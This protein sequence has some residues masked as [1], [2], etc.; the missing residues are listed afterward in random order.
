M[1]QIRFSAVLA[2]ALVM[3]GPAA[4]QSSCGS[5]DFATPYTQAFIDGVAFEGAARA[6]ETITSIPDGACHQDAVVERL[7][8]SLGP[9]VGYKAAATSAGA[10]RQLGLDG[11]VLG[12]LFED[13]LRPGGATIRVDQGA[14]LIFELDLLARVGD[15]AINEATTREEALEA[16]D[17]FVPFV[18][19]GD[20]MVP[21]GAP[22]TGPLLQAMNAG[23][24]LGVTGEPIPADGLTVDTLAA[25]TGT[26]DEGRRRRRRSA[27][28]CSSG[29]STR[30]RALDRRGRQLAWANAGTGGSSES[31]LHGPLP[32]RQA[33][34]RH[35]HLR[36]PF[37]HAGNR[38]PHARI[39]RD[40]LPRGAGRV[41]VCPPGDCRWRMFGVPEAS[42][43][44]AA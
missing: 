8:E 24:R 33:R 23:A 21:A 7:G 26:D 12:I 19:L 5:Y 15:E 42:W 1:M 39:G 16:I 43:P 10:Q 38:A 4:S 41:M 2:A 31:W 20:L 34:C 44:R 18:E 17:A 14:R 6:A 40:R 3:A 36:R 13:M 28:H 32:A 35:R 25:V 9:V 27:G 22:I 30:C 29:S 37:R 11:P